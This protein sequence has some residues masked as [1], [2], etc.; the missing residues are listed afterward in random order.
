[1]ASRSIGAIFAELSLRD[2]NFQKGLKG[3][4]KGLKS[5]NKNALNMF[6]GLAGKLVAAAGIGSIGSILAKSIGDASDLGETVSKSEQIFGKNS[7]A[8]E[9]WADGAADAMGQSKQEA[10][11]AAATMGN[12]FIA[13]KL[14]E[15]DAAS[16]SKRMVE[17]AADLASFNNTSSEDAI[18]AIGAALRGESEPIR[19]YGVLLD[20]ATLKAKALAMGLYDGKGA[21]EPATRAMAAYQVILTQTKVAQ[22]DFARTSDGLANSQKILKANLENTT[23]EIGQGLL[24]GL[25]KFSAALKDVDMVGFGESLGG[26]LGASMEVLT[27]GNA[28]EIFKLQGLAAWEAIRSNAGFADIATVQKTYFDFI[29]SLLPGGEDDFSFKDKINEHSDA[30]KAGNDARQQEIADKIDA[31]YAEKDKKFA[32]RI[33]KEE[34]ERAYER[35]R[36]FEAENSPEWIDPNAPAI[37]VADIAVKGDRG[38]LMDLA[39][40]DSYQARGLSLSKSPSDSIEDKQL[41]VLEKVRDILEKASTSGALVWTT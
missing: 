16:M 40:N 8:M 12:L 19:R 4:S 41:T 20:D 23:A 11:G 5:F 34:E 25:L 24:P 36:N 18:N 32:E 28:W 15:D 26:Y 39:Q 1:M 13:M 22:G 29:K 6:T 2:T 17:L 35:A 37:D 9:K 31:I 33:A 7:K 27:D 38:S 14:G 21:L 30:T 3:A 10:L